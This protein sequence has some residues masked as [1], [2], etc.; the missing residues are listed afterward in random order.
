MFRGESVGAPATAFGEAV[1]T[2]GDDRLPGGRR[3]T[4][5]SAGR[6]SASPRRWSATTASPSTGPSPARRTRARV[7]MREA[8]GPEWTDWLHEHGIPA[9]TGIDTRSLALHLRE[10]GAHARRASS[11]ARRRRARRS[12]RPRASRRW[13]APRSPA[14]VSTTRAVRRST[15]TATCGRGRR[16][17]RQALDPAP[18]RRGAAPRSRSSRTTSTPTRS[19]AFDGVVLSNGPGDPEPLVE[20]GGDRARAAR[21]RAGAR[22]LPRPPAARARDRPHDLQAAVRPPRREP[23]GARARDA[24]ACS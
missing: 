6:S 10:R 12:S 1:F 14:R 8:R 17:R 23:P 3:P 16:L 15:K 20:R 24:A 2:T 21:P 22:D 19:P 5:A 13:T 9:L 7:V 4:R 11:P 18:A